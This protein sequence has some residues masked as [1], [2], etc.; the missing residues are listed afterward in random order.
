[1]KS[2]NGILTLHLNDSRTPTSLTAGHTGFDIPFTLNHYPGIPSV[3]PR[4][5]L[6][7]RKST[8]PLRQAQRSC[9]V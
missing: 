8:S 2:A 7:R 1:M 3:Q 9:E 4:L 6:S 5:F